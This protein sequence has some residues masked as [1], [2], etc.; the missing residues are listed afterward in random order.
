M[1]HSAQDPE[2]HKKMT[3]GIYVFAVLAFFFYVW[4]IFKVIC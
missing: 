2:A 1:N 3:A 4:L